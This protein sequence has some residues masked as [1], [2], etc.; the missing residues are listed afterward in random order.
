MHSADMSPNPTKQVRFLEETP[1]P[2][3]TL[4]SEK[5]KLVAAIE[6]KEHCAS[7]LPP[8]ISPTSVAEPSASVFSTKIVP[9]HS[10]LY[11]AAGMG[12]VDNFRLLLSFGAT[13]GPEGGP[14]SKVA[15][16]SIAAYGGQ[17]AMVQHLLTIHGASP[18]QKYFLTP[19]TKEKPGDSPLVA[20]VI[21]R[22]H[23]RQVMTDRSCPIQD[24]QHAAVFWELFNAGAVPREYAP[25]RKSD[26]LGLLAQASKD[27]LFDEKDGRDF[28][29]PSVR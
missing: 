20:A 22:V 18:N 2:P 21:G 9:M 24:T 25:H 28:T 27:R 19:E 26:A 12:N 8:L 7:F 4:S 16:L 15:M 29:T 23:Y 3:A 14:S 11:V 1:A 17:L 6:L 5:T 10:P 13:F